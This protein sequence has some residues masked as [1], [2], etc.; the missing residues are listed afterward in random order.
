MLPLKIALRFM[1]SSRAQT[2]LVVLGISIGVSVQVFVGT[3]IGSL[4]QSLIDGTVGNSP[5]V[6]VTSS[7]DDPVILDSEAILADVMGVDGLTA[8]SVS[9]D[10]PA[11]LIA[12]ERTFP[13]LVRG[14]NVVKADSI[15]GILGAIYEGAAPAEGQIMMGKDLSEDLGVG[16]GDAIELSVANGSRYSYIVSGLFD[17]KVSSINEAWIITS[18]GSAQLLFSFG[19]GVTSIEFKIRDVFAADAVAQEMSSL[20]AS[21]PVQVDNWKDQNE[22]LLSGLQGQTASSLMIQVFV[23]AAVVIAIA[24]VLAIKVVQ[25][26]R[27]IG[28]LKAMGMTDRASS[29][30]FMFEGLLLGLAGSLFGVLLGVSLLLSFV[31]FA[32]NPDGSALIDLYLDHWFIA[33]SGVVAVLAATLAAVVPALKSSKLSPIEVIRNA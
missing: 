13:V 10:S 12:G 28:I 8:S 32:T 7:Q 22:Q 24:S 18:I 2:V 11:F 33:G 25:K 4:Q 3:L 15:Y 14:W 19:D 29:M 6:T 23:L 30:V 26:S 9:A 17:L 27:Q 1:R 21:Y 20:L 5:H 31:T 16:P